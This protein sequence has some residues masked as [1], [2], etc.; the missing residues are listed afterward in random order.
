MSLTEA[1]QLPNH[2]VE[3]WRAYYAVRRQRQELEDLR[4][5]DRR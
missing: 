1:R 3:E 2:E 4:S 5:R